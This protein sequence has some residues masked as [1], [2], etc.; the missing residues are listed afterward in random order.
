MRKKIVLVG[1]CFDV[2]H[3][4]H[5]RFLEKAKKAGEYLIVLLESDKK[6][7]ELKGQDRPIHTQN[8]RK[9]ILKGLKS[10]DRV[11]LLPYLKNDADYEVV[12][13]QIKPDIIAATLG[14]SDNHHKER[15]AKA[16]GAKLKY[17]TKMIGSYSTSNIL[18]HRT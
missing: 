1:G 16:T 6:I 3:P 18:T 15:I 13:Q 12:I 5:I 8:E 2:L 10:V 14:A 9:L 17:V 11:I 7:K 4:G